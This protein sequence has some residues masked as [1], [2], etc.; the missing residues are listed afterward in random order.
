[1]IQ[2]NPESDDEVLHDKKIGSFYIEEKEQLL[3]EDSVIVKNEG[4]FI[5][6]GGV[7]YHVKK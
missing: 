2:Y 7:K 3:R 6:I 4:M 1:M 5:L